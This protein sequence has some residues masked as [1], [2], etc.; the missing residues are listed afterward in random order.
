MSRVFG[1]TA[2]SIHRNVWVGGGFV[3]AVGARLDVVE[4]VTADGAKLEGVALGLLAPDD[5]PLQLATT[6]HKM[7]GAH[8]RPI[9]SRDTRDHR[10]SPAAA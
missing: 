5:A 4:G 6:R 9:L 10:L 2:V 7:I 8:P 1:A 3:D